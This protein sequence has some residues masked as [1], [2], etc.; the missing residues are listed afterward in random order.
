MMM[1][2]AVW[3]IVLP[4]MRTFQGEGDVIVVRW[5]YVETGRGSKVSF[6]A[7]INPDTCHCRLTELAMMSRYA[8][9]GGGE[10]HPAPLRKPF[11]F[12]SLAIKVGGSRGAHVLLASLLR[13][14]PIPNGDKIHILNSITPRNGLRVERV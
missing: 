13:P 9:A 7:S 4:W 10:L 6:I 3:A 11:P 8:V 1:R 5:M 12:E 2:G 14:T